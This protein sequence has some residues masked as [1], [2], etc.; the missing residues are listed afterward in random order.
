MFLLHQVSSVIS[1]RR[2][3]RFKISEQADALLSASSAYLRGPRECRAVRE[4]FPEPG[5]WSSPALI[6]AAEPRFYQPTITRLPSLICLTLF[7]L[8]LIALVEL[9]C[10]RLPA[11][12]SKGMI[13]TEKNVEHSGARRR[14]AAPIPQGELDYNLLVVS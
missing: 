5:S 9:A 8:S 6:G 10:R 14:E 13:G 12:Q 11:L 4:L 7:S 2:H 1:C 3:S